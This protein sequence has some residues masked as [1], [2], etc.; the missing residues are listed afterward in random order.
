MCGNEEDVTTDVVGSTDV[1]NNLALA[2]SIDGTVGAVEAVLHRRRQRRMTK[3][4]SQLLEG[5]V[6]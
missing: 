6:K 2:G 3:K 4:Y 5:I 1:Y